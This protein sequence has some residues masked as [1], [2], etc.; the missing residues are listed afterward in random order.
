MSNSQ[1]LFYAPQC[2]VEKTAGEVDLADDPNQWPQMILQEL[3]KQV[4]YITDYQPHVQME[5]VD[6]ERGYGL[7]H[8]EIQ[9]QTEAPQDSTRSNG[10][11]RNSHRPHPVCCARE[12]AVSL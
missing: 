8:V 12:E 7:G 1:P 3:Y 5:R 4:P 6:A 11:C 9:N 2:F 10:V